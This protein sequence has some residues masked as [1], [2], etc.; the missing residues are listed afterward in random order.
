MYVVLV[1]KAGLIVKQEQEKQLLHVLQLITDHHIYL[2]LSS[3]QVIGSHSK[4]NVADS[5]ILTRNMKL[6]IKNAVN[7]KLTEQSL[8]VCAIKT[9]LTAAIIHA[10]SV[11]STVQHLRIL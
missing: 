2:E 8:G 9:K 6:F 4:P 10:A 3:E 1:V 5:V 7:D 11:M